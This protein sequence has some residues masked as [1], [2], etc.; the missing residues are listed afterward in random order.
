M[1]DQAGLL[2]ANH[3]YPNGARKLVGPGEADRLLQ[4]RAKN[5]SNP[6]IATI[7][8]D[9][10]TFSEAVS[11]RIDFRSYFGISWGI[12]NSYNL[13]AIDAKRGAS[14][15]VVADTLTV[16]VQ[17]IGDDAPTNWYSCAVGFGGGRGGRIGNTFTWPTL[18][19]TTG[20][21]SSTKPIMPYAN[22]LTV[23]T[24]QPP[25][26]WPSP[27][28]RFYADSAG[29]SLLAVQE[30]RP[31]EDWATIPGGAEYVTLTN[32]SGAGTEQFLLL[33]DIAI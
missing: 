9:V 27:L 5:P 13:A 30:I 21:E 15:S 14:V 3:R 24:D 11:P 12:G 20:V 7:Q 28:V 8:F 31:F 19:L 18:V 2:L 26:M 25:T 32:Q 4:I 16:D 17:I 22:R 33:F 1:W 6:F 23:L 29:S 10:Q